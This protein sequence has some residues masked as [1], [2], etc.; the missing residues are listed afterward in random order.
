MKKNLIIS[1]CRELHEQNFA[2]YEYISSYNYQLLK[3]L[4]LN[5]NVSHELID[6]NHL[7]SNLS[8]LV[9]FVSDQLPR[10]LLTLSLSLSKTHKIKD[11]SFWENC[12]FLYLKDLL[13]SSYFYFELLNRLFRPSD[14]CLKI[15]TSPSKPPIY[16][17][18]GVNDF[19]YWHATNEGREFYCAEYFR[20]FYPGHFEESPLLR[21][22]FYPIKKDERE[23]K[24]SVLALNLL[25]NFTSRRRNNT[26]KVLVTNARYDHEF[27]SD[28][29]R[30]SKNKIVFQDQIPDVAYKFK[31]CLPID[32][33]LRG[34][35]ISDLLVENNFDK[36]FLS[37]L[38][39]TFPYT[40]AEGFD[41]AFSFYDAH[42][43]SF[44]KL[45]S[46]ASETQYQE[47][48]LG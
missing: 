16:G 28:L 33:D 25:R 32:N 37:C 44:G 39:K 1:N 26:T 17:T 12:I 27:S 46:I 30:Y 42:W 48:A 4:N 43:N 38:L 11:I 3:I 9:S 2:A 47:H 5:D 14:H 24:I 21:E 40:F 10:Y 36:Y 45:E 23:G 8:N 20:T 13:A 35:L 19:L 34:N 6:I 15:A 22:T 18:T 41:L 7:G 29:T 31:D